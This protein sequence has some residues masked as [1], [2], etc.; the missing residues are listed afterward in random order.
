MAPKANLSA[1]L[2]ATVSQKAKKAQKRQ[3]WV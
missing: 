2:V 3:K 1:K